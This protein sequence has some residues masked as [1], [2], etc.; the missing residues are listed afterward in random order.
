MSARTQSVGMWD[1]QW[2]P[3]MR[4]PRVD[5]L[6]L[7]IELR[8]H[9]R[10][11]KPGVVLDVGARHSPYRWEI[12]ATRYLT[13]DAQRTHKPDICSDIQD[14]KWKS[15]FF[16]TVIATEVL[17]HVADPQQA[18][19]EIH[20]VLKRGGICILSTR[21]ICPYHPSPK[22]YYR[23]TWDSLQHLFQKFRHVEVHSH[24][25]R[26]QV[27]WNMLNSGRIGILLNIF[28][29]L[30]A[31]LNWKNMFIHCGYVVYAKK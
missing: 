8:K 12:P 13:L 2:F 31:R 20:R 9:F 16:D 27:L 25:N 26:L 3:T 19:A 14:I 4:I 18:I 11:L 24:G 6:S 17:E 22:D 30:I 1:L 29:P 10:R 23:F 5:R 15:N 7:D 21:F 28:N